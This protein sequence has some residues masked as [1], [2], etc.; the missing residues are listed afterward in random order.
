MEGSK[1]TNVIRS[2]TIEKIK[3][4][5]T[6]ENEPLKEEEILKCLHELNDGLDDCAKELDQDS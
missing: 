4:Q 3:K 5:L 2:R 1:S 6:R